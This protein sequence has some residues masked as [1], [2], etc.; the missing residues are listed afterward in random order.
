[1]RFPIIQLCGKWLQDSGFKAG[2]RI[3]ITYQDDKIIIT[4]SSVQ[5]F[6]DL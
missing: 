6:E 3:D 1:M 2:H 5:R 4:K